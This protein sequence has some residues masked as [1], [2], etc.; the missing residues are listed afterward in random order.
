[1]ADDA[2]GL[3]VDPDQGA[4]LSGNPCPVQAGGPTKGST[5]LKRVLT[6]FVA[7]I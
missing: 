4:E 1:V 3:A 6:K 5:S 2:A 7:L